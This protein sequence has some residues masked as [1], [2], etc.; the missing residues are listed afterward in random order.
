[1]GDPREGLEPDGTIR[2]GASAERIADR[3][4]ALV[5]STIEAVLAAAPAAS[6]YAYGSVTTG[7][8]ESPRSD[9]DVLTIGLDPSIAREIALDASTRFSHLCRGV[10]IAAG[11][12][13]DF[14]GDTSESYGAQVFLHHYC[15]HLTGPDL[16][17][18]VTGFAGDRRAARGFN[19]DIGR[20]AE[21]WRRS[22]GEVDPG[23]LGRRIA[24][25]TLL[26]CAGLVSVHDGTWT[27]DRRRSARRWSE[28]H[29]GLRAGLTQLL[30]L[31]DGA[32]RPSRAEVT[33][34][35]DDVVDVI[36]QQFADE[37]GLW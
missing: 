3:Y 23:D 6:V 37:I 4:R 15:I 34:N 7:Q 8:A 31:A 25:K 30:E 20:H 10:E 16:D 21:R 36:A 22:L 1:M 28:I 24:R 13:G 12:P 18:A 35:L 29:P 17:R 19:G 2:T 32:A 27:T 5:A 26:A 33:A 14:V 11:A 9:V